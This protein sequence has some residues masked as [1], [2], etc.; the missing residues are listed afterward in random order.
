MKR[1]DTVWVLHGDEWRR[2]TVYSAGSCMAAVSLGAG[3]INRVSLT[4]GALDAMQTLRAASEAVATA[5]DAVV[6]AAR[7]AAGRWGSTPW[8]PYDEGDSGDI[9]DAVRHLEDAERAEAEA[10]ARLEAL[11]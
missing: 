3:V 11:R 2:G 7:A 10:R 4:L 1:G 9:T 8:V 5:R 6:E